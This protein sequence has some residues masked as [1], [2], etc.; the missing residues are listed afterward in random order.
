MGLLAVLLSFR[1][2]ANDGFDPGVPVL[3]LQKDAA[4]D[5]EWML[6]PRGVVV[7]DIKARRSPVFIDL[8]EWTW[9]DEAYTCPPDIALGPKGEALVSSN[10]VPSLWRIDPAS[11]RVT[12]HDL[13]LDAHLDKDVGFTG[14]V[15]APTLG[16][17]FAVSEY[18]ALWRI[19]PLLRRAQEI[20]LNQPIG[21]P[22][23]LSELPRSHNR[24]FRRLIGLCAQGGGGH[25]TISISPDQ[26]SGYVRPSCQLKVKAPQARGLS[27][28]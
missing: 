23:A 11:L 4:R 6:T 10:V 13:V 22:C 21:R 8:P 17:Y 24:N 18:G 2:L 19:D 25:W 7:V 28:R 15:Y 16:V 9:A 14:L 3:R 5:R 1:V 20:R 26:R 12:R 27:Q